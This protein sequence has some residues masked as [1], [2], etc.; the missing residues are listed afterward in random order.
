VLHVVPRSAAAGAGIRAGDIITKAGS[1]DAPSSGQISRL[2]LENETLVFAVTRDQDH[3]VLA[4]E[5]AR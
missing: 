1:V 4:I 3:R 5:K 2:F